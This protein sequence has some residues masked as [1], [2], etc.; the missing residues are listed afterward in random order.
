MTDGF[1]SRVRYRTCQVRCTSF[2][3]DLPRRELSPHGVPSEWL[4]RGTRDRV[5]VLGQQ[6]RLE[7]STGSP[8]LQHP[9]S[10][11]QDL[12]V[13]AP[14]PRLEESIC[15]KLAACPGSCMPPSKKILLVDR[16]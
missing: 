13:R 7:Q 2:R 11:W 4:R 6:S 14:L 9:G 8:R 5:S 16:M 10:T 12:R 3:P 1:S 15:K